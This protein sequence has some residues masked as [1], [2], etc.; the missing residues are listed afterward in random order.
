MDGIC[1]AGSAVPIRGSDA[2]KIV[3]V[4]RMSDGDAITVIDSAGASFAARVKIDGKAV[5]AELDR[6]LEAAQA[7]P[8]RVTLAQGVPK[9]QK[10]D[11]IVE[12]TTELGAAAIVPLLT[13]RTVADV[14]PNKRERWERLARTA[15]MQCGRDTV[16]S[17]GPPQTFAQLC[18]GFASYDRVIV[19]WELAPR[20]DVRVRL[21][22][23]LAA[24][25]N[26]LV[27]IGPEGGFS[28]EEAA[29]AVDSGA[30]TVWLGPRILR[31]ET[32]GIV[33][34]AFINL[35]TGG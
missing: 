1:T 27:V 33:A 25:T 24:A 8:V 30:Q 29:L 7:S 34:L 22:S 21:E 32:A 10:M 26:V 5:Q 31:T 19:P 17:I 35:L 28:H 4:L 23:L 18:A 16:P 3:S 14:T 15:S 13:E 9:A 20:D 6:Q 11:Y 2:R 12:K